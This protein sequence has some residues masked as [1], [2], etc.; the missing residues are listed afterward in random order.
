MTDTQFLFFF[1]ML[2]MIWARTAVGYW[3]LAANVLG[4]GC[5]AWVVCVVIVRRFGK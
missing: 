4:L 5:W 1:G 3:E 2:L